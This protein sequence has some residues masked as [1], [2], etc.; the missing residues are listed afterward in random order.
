MGQD[1]GGDSRGQEAAPSHLAGPV[2]ARLFHGEQNPSY[3]RP[4]G[5]LQE[6]IMTI[7]IT[8]T[9]LIVIKIMMMMIMTITITTTLFMIMITISAR[10]IITTIVTIVTTSITIITTIVIVVI[11]III[12]IIIIVEGF[13]AHDE[14]GACRCAFCVRFSK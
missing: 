12:I 14:L 11:I 1:K 6:T 7:K 8:T 13:P 3:R 2:G 4:K 10:V 9:L 5:G